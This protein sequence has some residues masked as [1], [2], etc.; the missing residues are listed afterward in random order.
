V[1]RMK[2]RMY[3]ET[4][5]YPP[6]PL[7]FVRNIRLMA[8]SA[9]PPSR[10]QNGMDAAVGSRRALLAGRTITSAKAETGHVSV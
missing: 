10:Q 9:H 5:Q 8:A 3:T 6:Q 7:P 1:L 2:V 4:M